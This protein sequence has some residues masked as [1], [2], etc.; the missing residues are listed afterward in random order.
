MRLG[1]VRAM[2]FRDREKQRLVNLRDSIFNDPGSGLFFGKAREFVLNDAALNLWEGVRQDALEY[3]KN[4]DISWWKGERGAHRTF[5]L[6]PDRVRE[7]LVFSA[8]KA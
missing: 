3:F 1:R 4:N 6:F 5:A 7:S 8:A 2:G